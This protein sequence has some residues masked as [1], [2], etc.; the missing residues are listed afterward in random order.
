MTLLPLLVLLSTVAGCGGS[1]ASPPLPPFSLTCKT[2][3]LASGAVRAAVTVTSNASRAGSAILY[4]PVLRLVTHEYPLLST[5]FVIER[6]NGRQTS[7][8]GFLVPR[9]KANGTAHLLLRFT[10]PTQSQTVLVT[11]GPHVTGTSLPSNG[12]VIRGR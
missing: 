10:R 1:N 5:R 8:I 3:L 2:R 9:I 6:R 7:E 4:G 12:C 11:D